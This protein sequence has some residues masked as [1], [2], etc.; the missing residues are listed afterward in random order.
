MMEWIVNNMQG[1][2]SWVHQQLILLMNFIENLFLDMFEL[3]MEG[4]VFIFIQIEPPQ[5]ISEGMGAVFLHLPPDILYFFHMSGLS[6]G[7]AIYG[8]GFSFYL[9]R[10]L[11]TLGQW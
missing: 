10:K 8:T 6:S 7:L 5:F 2:V 9:L 3:L 1:W 11:A 4:V